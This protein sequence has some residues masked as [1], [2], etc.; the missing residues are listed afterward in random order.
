M[1]GL[2]VKKEL[3]EILG[4]PRFAATFAVVSLLILLS[5]YLGAANYQ[6]SREQYEA[7]VAEDLRQ[8]EGQ[9]DWLNIRPSI[10]LP[11]QPLASLVNGISNDVG[12]TIRVLGMGALRPEGSRFNE[13]PVLAMFRFLDLE[14]TFLVVLSL[15]AILFAFDL[16]SGEKERGT[17]RLALSNAVPRD[18]WIFGKLVGAFLALVVPLL[19][20]ILLGC[21]LFVVMGVPLS[22][23]E[24]LRLALLVAAG[25]LYVGAFLGMTVLVSALT[26]QSSTSFLI[27]LVLWIAA[28][29]I[30]PRSS[31]LLAA[32]SVD[33]PSV[34]EMLSQQRRLRTQL[35]Q[36]D[37][38]AMREYLQTVLNSGTED[39]DSPAAR[40]DMMNRFNS[41]MQEQG[42]KRNAKIEALTARLEEDR[43]NRQTVQQALAFGLA[44]LSPAAAFSLA[45]MNLA[46]TAIDLPRHYLD[47]AKAYQEAF[48]R[49]Q[50]EKTGMS[51]GGMRIMIRTSDDEEEEEKAIDPRE[52]PVFNFQPPRAGEILRGATLDLGLLALFNVLFTTGAF[53]AFMRYDV[54]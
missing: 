54:R 38:V 35:W 32:R 25:M 4:T 14:F 41:F 29:M 44:R 48:A 10:F 51:A 50:K 30:L 7:A 39:D 34:D 31:V 9:T 8:M 28:V 20:P 42:E 24:W 19:I 5:F 37:R 6:L 1:F 46:G 12:R 53:V 16:I 26:H 15:F 11:P 52:L 49:F 13:E 23:D 2:I 3:R 27:V 43:T 47:Q 45:S 18:K 33:V 22:G 36:E 17:L 40:Q 21:L